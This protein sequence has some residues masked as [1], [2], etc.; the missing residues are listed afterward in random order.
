MKL[1]LLVSALVAASVLTACGG[2]GGGGGNDSNP[3]STSLSGVAAKGPLKKAVVKAFQVNE[4]GVVGT[5]ALDVKTTDDD[6]KYVLTLGS[7]TGSVQLEVTTTADT[8]SADEAT[9]ND[10][11]LPSNFTLR[12]NTV[13]KADDANRAAITPF[14]ELAHNIAKD[15]GGPTA[16]NIVKANGI[17]FTLIGVDPVATLPVAA[18]VPISGTVTEAQKRYGLFNA[19]ISKLASS[20]PTTGDPATNACFASAGT[21][22]GKRIQCASE[23]IAKSV[24]VSGSGVTTSNTKLDGLAGALLAVAADTA[25]NK[26]GATVSSTDPAIKYIDAAVAAAIDDKPL[27]IAPITPA[28]T[29]VATARQFFAGLRAN[30][31]ALR[32]GTVDTGI[33]D[34]VKAFGDSLNTEATALTGSS[35]TAVRS[36]TVASKLW[37]DYQAGA[38]SNVNVSGF[39]N[40]A[41]YCTVYQGT[42]PTQFGNGLVN[43]PYDTTPTEASSPANAAWVGCRV[44]DWSTF[45]T[46]VPG[47]SSPEVFF[48]TMFFNM[49]DAT[50]ASVPYLAVTSGQ[51]ESGGISYQ[52]NLTPALSGLVGFT[53]TSGS[54]T[55]FSIAGGL[56]PAATTGGTLLAAKYLV[57][58]N[59]AVATDPSGGTRVSFGAGKLSVVPVGSDTPG[60]VIDLSP[61]GASFAVIPKVT[62]DATQVAAAKVSLAATISDRKGRLTG[63]LL[64]DKMSVDSLGRL[65]PGHV[66]FTG[67]IAA[68]PIVNGTTGA[69]VTFL[70]GDLEATNGATPVVSFS[71]RM[72]LPNRPVATLA[73]AI[74]KTSVTNDTF[75]LQGRYEQ[76]GT[77]VTISGAKTATG[78]T[79]TFADSSG[80]STTVTSTAPTANVTVGGRQTAV[81][82]KDS[83]VITY[84]DDTFE[85]LI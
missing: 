30:A 48:Q 76:N 39:G 70:S 74:T 44:F 34:G 16:A 65:V 12:A 35:V 15:S 69:V 11:P 21:D 29:D 78:N 51:Y 8:R 84:I 47:S 62:T 77:V 9:G 24:S 82:D 19:A 27:T 64:V 81:I 31:A 1:R 23:Q 75:S 79:A 40:F 6:G 73:V 66:K 42:F 80:V 22:P 33:A 43:T 32:S 28:G 45:S 55:G 25:I 49:A 3:S 68:A 5:A 41:S 83:S 26:T 61:G 13:V 18:N 37:N 58:I 60:L 36:A 52:R 71:G 7:Y 46:S 53:L 17:V 10:V 59:G 56:P 4:A 14:T 20:T 50:L 2:G 63:T 72:T 57:D 67:A 54:P 38:M 85:S